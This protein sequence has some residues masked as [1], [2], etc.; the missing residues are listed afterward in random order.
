M[1]EKDFS[2]SLCYNYCTHLSRQGAGCLEQNQ[3]FRKNSTDVNRLN[4]L[5]YTAL[6]EQ[7]PSGNDLKRLVVTI[8][9]DSQQEV[10]CGKEAQELLK[11]LNLH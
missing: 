1:I 9:V 3:Q 6:Y 10:W 4:C 5:A 2:I 11:Q 8:K 7:L